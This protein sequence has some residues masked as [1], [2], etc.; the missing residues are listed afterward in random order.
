MDKDSIQSS[1][2]TKSKKKKKYKKKKFIISNLLSEPSER[3]FFIYFCEV[4]GDY[5]KQFYEN[6]FDLS[7]II[8]LYFSDCETISDSQED[9]PS[10]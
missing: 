1:S 2:R 9:S 8:C 3:R 5:L 7:Y 6:L 4:D 10:R